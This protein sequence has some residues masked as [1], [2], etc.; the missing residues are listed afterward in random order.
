MSNFLK[1]ILAPRQIEYLII[2]SQLIITELSWGVSRFADSIEPIKVG[3][4]VLAVFPE[5]IGLEE[6]FNKI[7]RNQIDQFELKGISRITPPEKVLYFDIF[8]VANP[9]SIIKE[10]QLLILFEDTT[11]WILKEQKITQVAKEYG[12][13]LSRLEKTKIYLD[14][15]INSILDLLIVTDEKGTIKIVNKAIQVLLNYQEEELLN[16]PIS[17]IF[18]PQTLLNPKTLLNLSSH[19]SQ[20]TPFETL[21]KAKTGK[22]FPVSFSCGLLYSDP[23]APQ[24]FVWMGRDM[25]EAKRVELHLRQQAERDRLMTR[26]TQR[27]HQ[28]LSLEITL[29]NTALEVRQVLQ[30]DRVLIYHFESEQ[31]GKVM[32]KSMANSR[33]AEISNLNENVEFNSMLLS[34][35]SQGITQALD[36]IYQAPV[37]VDF[38]NLLIQLKVKAH[39]IIPIFIIDS[40]QLPNETHLLWGLLI[41]HQC[42]YPRCWQQ[43]E[44]KLLEELAVQVAIAIQQAELYEQ[45]NHANQELEGLAVIDELT[46]LANRRHFDHSLYQE[47]NRLRRENAPLSLI[48]IDIDYFKQYNDT[49]GHLGGDFC[50]QEVARILRQA[51][52]RETN[53]AAR[54]G[55]EEFALILPNTNIEGAIQIAEILRS[56]VEALKIAHATSKIS[57]YI[58]VSIG[59]ATLIPK[60]HL[61][62]KMLLH[63]ADQTLYLAKNNGRNRVCWIST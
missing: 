8:I 49:Y 48:L 52:K 25:T 34:Y 5:F 55:G 10:N 30:A 58:T 46:Q 43:W 28:S 9:D 18:D 53:L 15:I 1:K 61:T 6:I 12:L 38:L 13:A 16:Q 42:D 32:A 3:F 27:I 23:D 20:L 17:I 19:S 37:D 63:Q 24:E 47:W 44:I 56:D 26:I 39:L 60:D 11:E 22:T 59:V 14:K 7:L 41:V 40:L 21:C 45:L 29:E 35:F 2:N 33:I 31:E 4:D 57:D 54:Y 51:G 62:P 36:D 50:L